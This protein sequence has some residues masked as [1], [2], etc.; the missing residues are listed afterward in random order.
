MN[1]Q[2]AGQDQELLYYVGNTLGNANDV[3]WI[4]MGSEQ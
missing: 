4:F 1:S 3:V 2:I